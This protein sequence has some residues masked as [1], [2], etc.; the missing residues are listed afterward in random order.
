MACSS[1]NYRAAT[2]HWF[3]CVCVCVRR[4]ELIKQPVGFIGLR[5]A[6]GRLIMGANGGSFRISAPS[7][8]LMTK[9]NA[10][11]LFRAAA[12]GGNGSCPSRR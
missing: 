7:L 11:P 12:F 10:E 1:S 3:R 2:V 6:A 8:A 9:P 5:A 4:R